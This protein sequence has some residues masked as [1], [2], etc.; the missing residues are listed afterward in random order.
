M[1]RR[2]HCS[3]VIC[4]QS[5]RLPPKWKP[6]PSPSPLNP[7]R[8]SSA[9]PNQCLR[10]GLRF[11]SFYLKLS[12]THPYLYS[13][14]FRMERGGNPSIPKKSPVL[15]QETRNTPDKN[16]TLIWAVGEKNLFRFDS[17]ILLRCLANPYE[18]KAAA[19]ISRGRGREHYKTN[20][21]D[22]VTAF[23]AHY[24]YLCFCSHY[25]ERNPWRAK[26]FPPIV[27]LAKALQ[28]PSASCHKLDI[29]GVLKPWYCGKSR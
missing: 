13:F 2:S 12:Q 7:S 15:A 21:I 20:H 4:L 29:F 11:L 1:L 6:Q 22:K 24:F 3:G 26:T 8:S 28:C 18:H 17:R 23:S 5:F 27:Q 14:F 16:P 25:F 19:H 9:P 10:Q